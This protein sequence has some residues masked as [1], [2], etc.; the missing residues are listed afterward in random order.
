MKQLLG[1]F[2]TPYVLIPLFIINALG[3]IYGYI[4]YG[5]QLQQTPAV[6]LPFVPD[7][8]TASLVFTIVIGLYI[9]GRRSGLA[10]AFAFIT[11]VKYGLWAVGM[12]V[13]SGVAGETLSWQHYMLIASHAGMALQAFLY[14]PYYRVKLWHIGAVAVWTLHNDVIDYVFGMYPWVSASLEPYISLIGYGTF[15]LSI[16]SAGVLLWWRLSPGRTELWLMEE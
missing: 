9:I 2:G 1:W 6:F 13:F 4:W 10:E 15:W 11:L 3:T 16:I 7:S 14:L 12:N 8:P 5:Q